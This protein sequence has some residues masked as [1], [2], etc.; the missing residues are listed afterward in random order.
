MKILLIDNYDSFTYNILHL[1]AVIDG[2]EVTVLRNDDEK[3]S[4]EFA[5]QNFD[6]V[7]IGPG[8]GDPTDPHYFGV[9]SDIIKSTKLPLLGICLGFQGLAVEHGAVLKKAIEPKHGKT[10]RLIHTDNEL[11]DDCA[12]QFAVMRYHS[13][14]IDAT[15]DLPKSIEIIGE[16]VPS[17]QSVL[18]NDREIMAIKI[19]GKPQYGVQFHP[20]SFATEYG[21]QLAKNFVNIMKENI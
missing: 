2:V 6:G 17:E 1:F 13:L 21:T 3:L 19:S 4:A 14:M 15:Q 8:P 18:E 11:F 7:I 5:N 10:S 12:E 9:N 20:E 16:V